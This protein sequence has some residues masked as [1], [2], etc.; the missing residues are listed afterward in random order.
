MVTVN[1]CLSF[2]IHDIYMDV[3]KDSKMYISINDV[4]YVFVLCITLMWSLCFVLTLFAL[5]LSVLAYVLS[6][7]FKCVYLQ[8][9]LRVRVRVRVHT[10]AY[11]YACI[12]A[13]SASLHLLRLNDNIPP[14]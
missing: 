1:V 8:V 5:C 10:C 4:R 6:C 11:A 12:L 14:C 2:Q 7:V 3:T 13:S 9:C